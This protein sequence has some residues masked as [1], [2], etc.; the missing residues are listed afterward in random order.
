VPTRLHEEVALAAISAG[1]ALIIEKPLAPTLLEGKRLAEAAAKAGVPFM[2]GHIERFNPAVQELRR[3]LQ[4][5]EAGRVLQLTARRLGPFAARTRDVGVIHDLAF[6]DIDVMRFLLGCEVER[7][8]AETQS[9]VRT[10]YADS[11]TGLLR[12]ASPEGAGAIGNLEVN[13]LTPRKIREL[14]A[15]GEH[16]YFVLDYLG[17]TLEFHQSDAGES[18]ALSGQAWPALANL[19]GSEAGPVVR[20]P[21]ET[22]EPLEAELSA[23]VDGVRSG[24]ALPVSSADALAT[25]AIAD[26]LSESASIGM[27]VTPKRGF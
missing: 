19:R 8:Y 16:G 12:F 15:L 17:Q 13:W 4:T 1:K 11:L 10:D 21:I 22:R 2:A 9:M 7:V 5:G 18:H 6:H 25:L 23:F 26:A 3:R 20:I 14:T 24:S 27:P